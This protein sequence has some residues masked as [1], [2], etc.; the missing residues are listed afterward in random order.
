M[1]VVGSLGHGFGI[2]L[3]LS[4]LL[5]G[6]IGAVLGTG[7]GVLPGLGPSATIA[8]L[9]PITYKIDP[10]SAVIMLSGIYYGAMFGGS[11]TSILL[12]IPGE[13]AS[14]VTCIDGYQ[15][16][17]QGRAGAAL[18]V[19]AIGSFFG[20]IISVAM[21]ALIAPTLANF[22]IKFGPPEYT[23]LLL[24]GLLMAVYLSSGSALKGLMMMSLGV[25]L[26]MIG[27]DLAF[28]IERFTFGSPELINGLDFV[29][30]AMGLFGISE[31]LMNLEEEEVR[32]IFKTSL[33][34]VF[35]SKEDWRRAWAPMLRGGLLGSCMGVLPGGGPVMSTFASY[36]IEKRI[37]KHPEQFG[38]GAI[39]GVVA[40]ET[41]NNAASTSSFIPLM[42]L[43]IPTNAAVAMIFMAMM[44]HGIRPG[45]MLLQ[46]NPDMFW[47]VIASMF[48]GNTLLLGLNLPLVGFWASLLKVPYRYLVLV[49]MVVCVIGAYSV[50]YSAFDVG[51]LMVFGVFG[52]LIR[53]FGFPIPPLVLALILTPKLERSFQQSMV[54]G[55]GSLTIFV[56][57][58]ISVGFLA[59]VGLLILKPVSGWLWSR[60]HGRKKKE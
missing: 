43:G 54:M 12:N 53:R 31:V 22:A 48:V 33:K 32:E 29:P 51:T 34:G 20:G 39:E 47:G 59:I 14:V 21:L 49:I 55:M 1:D 30:V 11:T 35:P 10:V 26:G 17:R 6:F 27:Q 15:M 57:R 16:A 8:L 5:Y 38:K 28:G 46:E 42:T 4:N 52:Y 50:N 13:N 60:R 58:P 25:I 44:I 2:A 36:T 41:A 19:C 45:P 3:T 23:S 7:I 9:L 56:T 37:S 24:L 40:P 18:G